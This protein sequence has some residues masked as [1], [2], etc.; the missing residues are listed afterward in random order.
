MRVADRVVEMNDG[1]WRGLVILRI[2]MRIV[3]DSRYS[4]PFSWCL[5]ASARNT[6]TIVLAVL[7]LAP[8][9][10]AQ[11]NKCEAECLAHFTDRSEA[12]ACMSACGW[13]KNFGDTTSARTSA[14]SE[15][16]SDCANPHLSPSEVAVCRKRC[17]EQR[18]APRQHVVIEHLE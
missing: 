16:I 15:C 14:L 18:I 5:R 13:D 12:L 2:P 6:Y 8:A 7:F 1:A 4:N 11:S 9:C 3:P 10:F 17:V